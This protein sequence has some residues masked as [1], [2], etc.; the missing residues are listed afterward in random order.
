M[1]RVV[2]EDEDEDEDEGY[3][4]D[5]KDSEDDDDGLENLIQS[6]ALPLYHIVAIS[7]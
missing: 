2:D 4:D 3:G 7:P 5:G 1:M 6:L